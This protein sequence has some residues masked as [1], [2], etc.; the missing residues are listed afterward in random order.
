MKKLKSFVL[1]LIIP[2]MLFSF[3]VVLTLKYVKTEFGLLT[4]SQQFITSSL[5]VTRAGEMLKGDIISGEFKSTYSNMGVVA[6]PFHTFGRINQDRLEFRI[7]EKNSSNWLYR[8][9]YN[10]DQFQPNEPFPMGFP[11]VSDSQDKIYQF[12][13]ESL[14]GISGNAV[15]LY[16]GYPIYLVKYQFNSHQ[17]SNNNRLLVNFL[18]HKQLNLIN[19]SDFLIHTVTY[20][21]PL[22]FYLTLLISKK[23][24]HL[25][26]LLINLTI[27]SEVFLSKKYNTLLILFL[28]VTWLIGVSRLRL[29]SNFS[30]FQALILFVLVP[31]ALIVQKDLTSVSAEKIATWAYVFLILTIVH[32]IYESF[33]KPKNKNTLKGYLL[34]F[35]SFG[36]QLIYVGYFLVKRIT[37]SFSKSTTQTINLSH[38]FSKYIGKSAVEHSH[39]AMQKIMSF[40]NKLKLVSLPITNYATK[41]GQPILT[42]LHRM[43]KIIL[44]ILISLGIIWPVWQV[45]RGFKYCILLYLDFFPSNQLYYYFIKTGAYQIILIFVLVFLIRKTLKRQK[46]KTFL[47]IILLFAFQIGER[48]I[49]EITTDPFRYKITVWSAKAPK[50]IGW[51]EVEITGRNFKDLPFVGQVFVNDIEYDVLTWSDK[52]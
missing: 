12:E 20:L 21:L 3:W 31:T 39:T 2:L 4:L 47:I 6:I 22:I 34:S 49:F 33:V 48:K 7:K 42:L 9:T 32:K 16:S 44:N 35:S 5:L 8:A 18:Y 14:Q 30:A 10:T 28:I 15:V 36:L 24:P 37:N 13:I 1:W 11:T 46:G 41:S 40:S 27:F 25:F 23:Q 17:L 29:H 52:K 50:T 38:Y 45:I 51:Y 26:V 19:D 43:Q